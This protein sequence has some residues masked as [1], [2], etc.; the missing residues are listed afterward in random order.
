[1]NDDTI[2]ELYKLL[3]I[4]SILKC[5][6]INKQFYRVT[7]NET[8][9]K[10]NI[11]DVIKFDGSYYESFKFNYGLERV[12]IGVGNCN[13]S[14]VELYESSRLYSGMIKGVPTQIGLLEN[15]RYMSLSY[16]KLTFIPSEIGNLINLKKLWLHN[17]QLTYIP[18]E[19][20]NL[21]NLEVLMLDNNKLTSMPSELGNLKKLQFLSISNNPITHIPLTLYQIPN[22]KIN[23]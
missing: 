20:G 11:K 22:L 6:L 7:K 23:K 13:I 14:I 18:S 12:K 21:T 9:W 15:L 16:L 2:F 10:G 4:G 5:S 19:L 8:L 3:P 1:M 17:N